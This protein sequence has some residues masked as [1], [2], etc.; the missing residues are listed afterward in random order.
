MGLST[1]KDPQPGH[2]SLWKEAHGIAF[3][4]VLWDV[5]MEKDTRSGCGS[6]QS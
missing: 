5:P 4:L 6:P 2:G 3:G 1:T